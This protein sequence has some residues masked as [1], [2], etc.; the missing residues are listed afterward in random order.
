VGRHRPTDLR[1]YVRDLRRT[2]DASSDFDSRTALSNRIAT[3]TG[4]AARISVVEPPVHKSNLSKSLA[5]RTAKAVR[6]AIDGG[7]VPGGGHAFLSARSSISRLEA[8]DSDQMA[9]RRIL[10]SALEAPYR[11]IACNAGKH[12]RLDLEFL[13]AES[14]P[15]LDSADTLKIAWQVAIE[16]AAQALTIDTIVHRAKPE[17]SMVP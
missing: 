13:T 9:A 8:K 7:F 10:V 3:L 14:P 15:F 11:Q 17:V 16:G 2:Y 6:R 1:T 12:A 5:E 4:S